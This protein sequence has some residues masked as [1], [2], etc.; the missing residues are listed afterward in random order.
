M[1]DPL[2]VNVLHVSK[3]R[4]LLQRLAQPKSSKMVSM[5]LKKKKVCYKMV[6]QT[7]QLSR[8]ALKG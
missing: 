8:V 7:L 2:T 4:M 3:E 6:Y 1:F 5:V